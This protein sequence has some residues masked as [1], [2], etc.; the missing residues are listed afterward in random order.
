MHKILS[1]I[2][3]LLILTLMYLLWP[4]NKETFYESVRPMEHY[5]YENEESGYIPQ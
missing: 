1:I 5:K 2:I 4:R 3:I